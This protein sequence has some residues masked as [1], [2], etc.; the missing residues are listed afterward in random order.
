MAYLMLLK[1]SGCFGVTF[2]EVLSMIVSLKLA[3]KTSLCSFLFAVEIF[4][5]CSSL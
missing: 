5:L 2:C 4:H 1:L 3:V